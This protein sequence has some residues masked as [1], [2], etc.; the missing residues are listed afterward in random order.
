MPAVPK[1]IS[2]KKGN[3]NALQSLLRNEDAQMKFLL[4]NES[5]SFEAVRS[6]GFAT[7]LGGTLAAR[8]DGAA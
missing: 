2:A 4:R 7:W 8:R 6:A 5:F 1:I 3:P